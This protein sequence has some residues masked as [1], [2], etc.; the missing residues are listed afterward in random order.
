M[1]DT[2]QLYIVQQRKLGPQEK[3][4]PVYAK[5]MKSKEG[6]FEGVSFIRS[7]D[8]ATVMSLAEA[9]QAVAWAKAKKPLAKL[10]E[11]TVIPVE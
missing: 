9:Q 5:V 6:V 7:K 4:L 8:K 2:T 10:Y 3:D 11:T 1:T